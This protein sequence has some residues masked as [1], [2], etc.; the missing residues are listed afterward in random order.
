MK[1]FAGMMMAV[2]GLAMAEP[3]ELSYDEFARFS[4]RMPGEKVGDEQLIPAYLKPRTAGEV[5]D[6]AVANFRIR[7]PDGKIIPL[8]CDPL[9]VDPEA[10]LTPNDKKQIRAGFTHK[11]LIPKDPAKYAGAAMLNDLP[12]NFM[13]IQFPLVPRDP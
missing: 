4:E 6:L 9:P 8:K 2:A 10:G 5:I 1:Y 11:L 3:N 13:E 7:M 12:K